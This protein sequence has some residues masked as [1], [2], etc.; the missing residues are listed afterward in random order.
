MNSSFACSCIGKSK[1]KREVN[2]VN[3]LL[4]GKIISREIYKDET[5]P[6]MNLS[7]V[8]FKVLVMEKLKGKIATDTITL[9][10]GMGSGDCGIQFRIGKSYIIYANYDDEHFN[11]GIK[12]PKFLSTNICTRTIEF[13]IKEYNRIKK[14][15][16]RKGY[17]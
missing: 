1:M 14:Y 4:T 12:V 16:K 8:V 9:Y 2:N 10:T 6:R 3:V 7:K 15:V 17:C 5:Y 11:S 13:E